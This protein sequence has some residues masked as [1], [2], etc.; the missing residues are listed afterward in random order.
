VALRDGR[1]VDSDRTLRALS[2]RL[3]GPAS[4]DDTLVL[5]VE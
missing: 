2:A 3:A 1:L 4:P 5:E